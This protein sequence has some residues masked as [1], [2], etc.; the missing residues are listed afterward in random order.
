MFSSIFLGTTKVGKPDV[1][2]ATSP[3]FFVAVAGFVISRIKRCKF[4]FEVRD[5]WPEEIVAVGAIKN[6]YIIGALEALEMFLYRKADLIVAVAQGTIDILTRRGVPR[7]KLV[8]I[9]NGVDI[10]HFA[11]APN[12]TELRKR[13]GFEN[14]FV[15]C[16][17]GTHGMAHRLSDVLDAANELRQHK[18]IQFLFVGNGADKKNLVERAKQLKLDNVLFHDQIGRDRIPEFY[19][20]A[21]LFLVPLRKAPLFTKNIPSKIYEIMASKRP[22]LISTEGESRKLVERSGAG[23]GSTP[24]DS[25]EMAEKILFLCR[26][27]NLR[28]KMG[29][30]G[31]TF[32]VANASRKR[33]ANNYLAVLEQLAQGETDFTDLTAD[34][35]ERAVQEQVG[36]TDEVAV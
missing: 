25:H 15:A 32:A 28:R 14:K 17:L 7:S 11:N 18:D 24:E 29:D 1:L 8:L 23:I 3:Q 26:N 27:E 30:D 13:L 19:R 12:G 4:V 35:G 34:T 36:E 20:A 31:Y 9:Q 16:Y 5:V 22:I 33:L 2:I 21:D 10:E 6:R